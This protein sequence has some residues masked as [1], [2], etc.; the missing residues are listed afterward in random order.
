M[1]L[2][3]T[4][5]S[6][7]APAPILAV[8]GRAAPMAGAGSLTADLIPRRR[9]AKVPGVDL[10]LIRQER[11]VEAPPP[12]TSAKP[13]AAVAPPKPDLVAHDVALRADDAPSGARALRRDLNAQ[14]QSGGLLK[15]SALFFLVF[16]VTFA[17]MVWALVLAP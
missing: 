13:T 10:P 17:V 9:A 7:L 11:P 3:L 12:A 8:K 14:R 4:A 1:T 16:M 6:E 15:S 2:E 5:E